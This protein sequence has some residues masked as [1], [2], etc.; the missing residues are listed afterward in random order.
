MQYRHQDDSDEEVDFQNGRK[1]K[2]RNYDDDFEI[3]EIP[4]GRKRV[5]SIGGGAPR[6]N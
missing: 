6:Y 5:K 2:P 4:R 3:E 1:R